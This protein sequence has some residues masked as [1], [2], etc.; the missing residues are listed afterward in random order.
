MRYS[1]R[2]EWQL[3]VKVLSLK[4]GKRDKRSTVIGEIIYEVCDMAKEMS[5]NSKL[6]RYKKI[7]KNKT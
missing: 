5:G 4:Y 3:K 1:V 7:K 2:N 6:M